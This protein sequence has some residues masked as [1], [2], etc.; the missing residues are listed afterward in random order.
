VLT[1]DFDVMKNMLLAF[2]AVAA[3]V[4]MIIIANTFTI[5]LAQR[6]RQIG[7]LRA[8]GASGSQVRRKFLAEAILL[9]VLGSAGGVGL[10]VIVAIIGSWFVG[11]LTLG[12]AIPWLEVVGEFFVGVL[13]TVLAAI[14]PVLRSTRVSPLEALQPVQT[15]EAARA[16]SRV[17]MII[18]GLLIAVGTA[19]A[20][21]SQFTDS[22]P[23]AWALGGAMLLTLGVLG[24]A[25]LYV[26]TL[27]K[28]FGRVVGL[29]GPTARL[30]ATNAVR[31]PGRASATA[32]ALMLAVGL[33]VTLQV[34]TATVEKT[35]LAKIDE[36][37]PV[38][39]SLAAIEDW[40]QP[41][42]PD[43]DKPLAL[44]EAVITQARAISGVQSSAV[45]QGTRVTDK[46]GMWWSVSALTPESLA[47]APTAPTGIP[48][49]TILIGAM[50]DPALKDGG[51]LTVE[52]PLGEVTLTIKKT[53][54]VESTAALVSPDT[55]ATLTDQP[56]DNLMWIKL[57]DRGDM[58]SA[59][60][61][62]EPIMTEN[63]TTVSTSGGALMAYIIERVLNILLL[64]T[65]ALLGVAVSIALI[66]VSNT[67]GLSVIERT[68]ESA[69]LR[70]MGMQKSSL[71]LMLLVEAL[72]L[73]L[74]GV[75]VGVVAGAFFGWLGISAVL[76]QADLA[77]N[78]TLRFD[79]N[80]WL[81]LAMIAIAAVAA[82]LASIL[83]GRRAANAAPVEALAEE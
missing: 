48:T 80:P 47:A 42:T 61:D 74:T 50:D 78:T 70:A 22:W 14:V 11:T 24:G 5:L 23:L 33:I 29:T 8:V 9:G 79:V 67:L 2:S 44:P 45:L 71:R 15:T 62:L 3:L 21:V 69:L 38:D 39:I 81:T 49:G 51:K 35:V 6:R 1:R 18:C 59:F 34:G 60:L 27:L 65:S 58:A 36:H 64:I 16:S 57:A 76:R 72:L 10:G 53:N 75:I 40:R 30:A 26:P 31:N 68:R 77:D 66:G 52:A 46:N 25:P 73:A 83:P 55:L 56:V 7:L 17:R 20:V 13:I 54:L 12:I 43:L 28:I 37:Y 82:A 32:T 41:T 4:G 19:L 63:M